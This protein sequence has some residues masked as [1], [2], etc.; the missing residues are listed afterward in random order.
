MELRGKSINYQFGSGSEFIF[1]FQNYTRK[2]SNLFT[3]KMYSLIILEAKK[4]EISIIGPKSR[5]QQ[6]QT[7]F[8]G[9]RGESKLLAKVHLVKA[10]VFP[11]VIYGCET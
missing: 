11:V 1:M 6:G 7:S 2:D 9:S 8:G 10:M 3:V 4:F 5:S